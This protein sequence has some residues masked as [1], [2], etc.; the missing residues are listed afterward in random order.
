LVD[1]RKEL[2]QKAAY[3]AWIDNNR[4]GT[5]ELATGTGKTFVAFRAI[6]SMPKG[7]NCL[8]LAET[9]VN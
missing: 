9:T 4:I 5:A 2:I 1:N 8:I 3:D 6:L 7:A